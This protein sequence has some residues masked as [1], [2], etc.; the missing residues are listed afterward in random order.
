[1]KR[2]RYQLNNHLFSPSK[3]FARDS[4][5]GFNINQLGG[6]SKMSKSLTKQFGPLIPKMKAHKGGKYPTHTYGEII[7]KSPVMKASVPTKTM[8]PK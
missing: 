6:K 2:I 5:W 8:K 7:T 4:C 3:G 1:M